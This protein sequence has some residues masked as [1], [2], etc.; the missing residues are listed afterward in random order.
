MDVVKLEQQDD[1]DILNCMDK[2]TPKS[3]QWKATKFG[4]KLIDSW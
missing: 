3:A 4:I 2:S 1:E